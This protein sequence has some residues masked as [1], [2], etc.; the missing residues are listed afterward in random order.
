MERIIT[1]VQHF[2][3]QAQCDAAIRANVRKWREVKP[4][5]MIATFAQSSLNTQYIGVVKSIEMDELMPG[6]YSISV[7][8]ERLIAIYSGQDESTEWEDGDLFTYMTGDYVGYTMVERGPDS[9]ESVGG[10][11]EIS[12]IEADRRD[13]IIG[14]RE[15]LELVSFA[16]LAASCRSDESVSLVKAGDQ[17]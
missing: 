13:K 2:V 16:M 17:A 11:G 15:Y 6:R 14:E 4:G 8:F 12:M 1:P 3:S 7:R 10:T 9:E 5:D